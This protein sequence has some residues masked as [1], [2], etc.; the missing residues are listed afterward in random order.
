MNTES[1]TAVRVST[2]IWT[3]SNNITYKRN[4]KVLKRRSYGP[5]VI[6][7]IS[8]ECP[9]DEWP[10]IVNAHAVPD[11]IYEI[12]MINIVYDLGSIDSCEYELI[13][14]EEKNHEPRD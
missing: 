10:C 11:G 1:K 8:Y 6:E 3:D 2:S 12:K 9:Y 5:N 7:F 13:P 14:L 4:I